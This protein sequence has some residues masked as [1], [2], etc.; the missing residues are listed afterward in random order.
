MTYVHGVHVPYGPRAS[1]AA[2]HEVATFLRAHA[3]SQTCIDDVLLVVSE[4]VANAVHHARAR[5]EGGV[6]LTWRLL[7][8]HLQ[9]TVRDGGATTVPASRLPDAD[10]LDGRGLVLV[11]H[12]ARRWWVDA[13][14]DGSSV[15]ALIDVA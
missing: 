7:E 14:S 4:L 2:R 9:V 10:A 6:L 1:S 13:S 11:E 15:H 8:S 12:L 3:V 5:P